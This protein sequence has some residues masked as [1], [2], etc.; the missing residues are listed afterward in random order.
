MQLDTAILMMAATCTSL[1]GV[2]PV[3]GI[4]GDPTARSETELRRQ[5]QVLGRLGPPNI[6]MEDSQ[7]RSENLK[8]SRTQHTSG[9]KPNR[10]QAKLDGYCQENQEE[11]G[12]AAEPC[13]VSRNLT[14]PHSWC[15]TA[16]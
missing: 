5:R 14:D 6:R 13:A 15:L 11:L 9:M 3:L 10:R 1:N 2:L 4:A 7:R 16:S 8:G 12:V